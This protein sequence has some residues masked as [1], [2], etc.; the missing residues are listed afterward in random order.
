MKRWKK[1]L[2]TLGAVKTFDYP[3][4]K[5]GRKSPDKP[6]KLIAAHRDALA[7]A[8]KG[9]RGPVVLIGK[10]M[11]GR[12][13]CHVAVE[14]AAEEG[15]PPISAVVCLGYP[16]KGM[17]KAGKIRDA[18][19]KQMES[20][21]LFVQGTRDNLCPLDLL[22]KV[23]KKMKAENELFVVEA[24]NHSLE[25][26]KTQLKADGETQADVE[27]RALEAIGAFLKRVT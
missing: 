5:A 14:L 23:R 24:G 2:G 13:G 3:Y 10:S 27:K 15:S 26:T 22:E 6:D 7:S 1:S 11:G 8:R 17:G 21:T 12:I 18:V 20:P 19:L 25:A 4:M 9:H 16:L